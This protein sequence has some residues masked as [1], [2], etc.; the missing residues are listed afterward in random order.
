MKKCPEGFLWGGATAAFPRY[1][2]AFNE[3]NGQDPAFCRKIE[4]SPGEIRGK[5]RVT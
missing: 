4:L 2:I 1:R 5:F 3:I